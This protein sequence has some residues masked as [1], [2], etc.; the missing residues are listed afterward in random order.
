MA[1]S[2]AATPAGMRKGRGEPRPR[3]P[4]WDEMTC[5]SNMIGKPAAGRPRRAAKSLVAG[6]FARAAK[7]ELKKPA[8]PCSASL[9]LAWRLLRSPSRS[10][11]RIKGASA[12]PVVRRRLHRGRGPEVDRFAPAVPLLPKTS[13]GSDHRGGRAGCQNAAQ[14]EHEKPS[15]DITYGGRPKMARSAGV[16]LG[17]FARNPPLSGGGTLFAPVGQP[18]SRARCAP[19]RRLASPS[20]A[21]FAL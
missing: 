21:R 15:A 18:E 17:D 8:V 16:T 2:C 7:H 19:R 14:P 5:A 20:R 6:R 9:S 1:R 4:A 11:R 12:D 3:W 13:L 10:K